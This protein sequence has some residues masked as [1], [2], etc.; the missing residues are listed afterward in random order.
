MEE[1]DQLL[2]PATIPLDKEAPLP[3]CIGDFVA[4]EPSYG[5]EGEK[6]LAQVGKRTPISRLSRLQ[7]L[8]S[9]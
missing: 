8:L 6:H 9:D 3:H 4:S 5:Y 2:D 7:T 1:N